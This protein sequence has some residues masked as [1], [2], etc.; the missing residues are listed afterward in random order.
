[1]SL[2]ERAPSSLTAAERRAEV[3]EILAIGYV[4]LQMSRLSAQNGLA[5]TGQPTASCGSKA[6]SPQSSEDVA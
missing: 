5:D 2:R 3:A 4:R 6:T 1:M